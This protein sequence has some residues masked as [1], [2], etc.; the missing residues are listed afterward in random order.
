MDCHTH[1]EKISTYLSIMYFKDSQVQ[2]SKFNI[3]L[4]LKVAFILAYSTD[5]DEMAH[6]GAFHLG[7]LCLSKYMFTISR[8]K[9]VKIKMT[10]SAHMCN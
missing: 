2:I 3:F 1:I 5:P 10:A 6:Y 9:K 4:S 8:M 7:L